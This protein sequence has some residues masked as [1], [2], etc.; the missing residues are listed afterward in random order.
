MQRR[1]CDRDATDKH[2]HQ[3]GNRRNRP[4]TAH[5]HA[6]VLHHRHCL[7]RGKFMCHGKTGRARDESKPLLKL[8]PVHLIDDAVDV[9]R[10]LLA[11]AAN[12]LEKVEQ[13]PCTLHYRP[14]IADRQPEGCI[15]V[16]QRGMRRRHVRSFQHADPICKETQRALGGDARIKL[17]QAAGGCVARIG[18]LLLPRFPLP[19]IEPFEIGFVHQHF[20][21]HIEHCRWMRGMQPQWHGSYRSYVSGDVF[22]R[23][24][25]TA[26]SRLNQ[27]AVLVA[28]AD[29]EAIE[30]QFGGVLHFSIDLQSF[31]HSPI[32]SGN[33]ALVESVIQG[34]HRR[35]VPYLLELR[36][37]LATDALCRRIGGDQVRMCLLQLDQLA[38]H[39]VVF[40]IRNDRII[41]HI[42]CMGM[43]VQFGL[44]PRGALLPMILFMMRGRTR[45]IRK[46]IWLHRST[47][48]T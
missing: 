5:L 35:R 36:Q 14:L 18:E 33:I 26:R 38:E 10:Q 8:P 9:I 41:E 45:R 17:S 24:A 37:G 2:R 34:K 30:F 22:A 29:R 31:T 23:R 12:L 48:Q 25:I 19:R 46:Q 32:E 11:F 44:Q 7:F 1:I 47:E 15:P 16:E 3:P 40:G 4:G 27:N 6:N 13:P 20:A 21:A 43:P 28:Q 42:I 39:L